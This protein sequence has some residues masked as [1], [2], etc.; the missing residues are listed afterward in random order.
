MIR[1]AAPHDVATLVELIHDLAAFE[2]SPG[3][4]EVQ[5]DQLHAALFGPAPTVFAHVAVDEGEL[6]GMAVWYLTYSTWTG[7]HGIHL[8]D[9]YVRPEARG[10]H[11]GRA[12]LAELAGIAEGAGYRRVEW[13][14]L[15][16]NEAAVG[17]YRS[18]GAESMDEWIGYRLSGAALLQLAGDPSAN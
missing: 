2:R 5:P 7:V 15:D 11:F 12:L 18:L 10:R 17:F 6:V 4:V 3:S 14:V 8:E 1:P 9:L 16:W 13:D